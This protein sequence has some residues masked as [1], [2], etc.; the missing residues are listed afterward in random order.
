MCVWY[1]SF[2]TPASGA[3]VRNTM[4]GNATV[5]T[6]R[7]QLLSFFGFADRDSNMIVYVLRP[8]LPTP[9]SSGPPSTGG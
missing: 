8:T 5:Y 9:C 7:C 2:A 4:F 3:E 6:K 1:F